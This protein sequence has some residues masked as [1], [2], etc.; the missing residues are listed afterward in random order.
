MQNNRKTPRQGDNKHNFKSGEVYVKKIQDLKERKAVKFNGQ[1]PSNSPN[2]RRQPT[3]KQ[4]VDQKLKVRAALKMFL[5]KDPN[6]E[7]PKQN[8]SS[9]VSDPSYADIE[10]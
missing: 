8:A 2:N 10:N 7:T 4:Q 9:H 6:E 3:Q 5:G 1:S